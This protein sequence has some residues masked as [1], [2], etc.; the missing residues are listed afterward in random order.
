VLKSIVLLDVV[1]T[2]DCLGDLPLLEG[3]RDIKES[4]QVF[5]LCVQCG[6]EDSR[7]R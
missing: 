3:A 2:I 1:A 4:L 5:E 6:L 7:D